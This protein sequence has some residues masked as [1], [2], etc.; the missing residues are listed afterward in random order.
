M[1]KRILFI[2]N[3][4]SGQ[5][6]GAK[7]LADI[8]SVFS[9]AECETVCYMTRGRADATALAESEAQSA[10]TVVCAG[11]DGTLNEVITGLLKAGIDKPIGYIPCGSTNDFASTLGL[12]K[13]LK[14]AA[15]VAVGGEPRRLDAGRFGDRYFSYVAS[16][17]AFT[18]VS[19]ATS[20]TVKNALGHLA[21]VLSGI[22][23]IPNIKAV[24]ARFVID[25]EIFEDD[26]IFGAVSNST[27]LG[28]I[29]TL[30]EKDVSLDDGL[31]EVMLIKSPKNAAELSR[32]L[33]AITNK[34]YKENKMITFL[35]AKKI[36]VHTDEPLPWTLDG[37]YGDEQTDIVIENVP[38]AFALM[39]PKSEEETD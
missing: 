27:S 21:Y 5:R 14:T 17:G 28:G 15:E 24:H 32:L 4:A 36:E 12:P 31:L 13:N 9:A 22:K 7:A 29:F 6:K 11:G 23:D 10:D 20:Q 35:S 39:A 33:V 1:K 2:M 18:K 19:Y 26:Y 8:I 16:F 30:P 25:G 3:P 37:E 34:N 38:H